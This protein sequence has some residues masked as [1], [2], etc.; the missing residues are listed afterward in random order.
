MTRNLNL[1]PP[2]DGGIVT[3]PGGRAAH[4][5]VPRGNLLRAPAPAGLNAEALAQGNDLA[6]IIGDLTRTLDRL[7]PAGVLGTQTYVLDSSGQATEQYKVPFAALAVDSGSAS[8]LTITN[9]PRSTAPPSGP[10]VAIIKPRAF[11]L[12]NLKGYAWTIY[13]GTPGE[14]VTVQALSRP[15]APV[16]V[17]P[18]QSVTSTLASPYPY[19]NGAVPVSN[20]SGNKANAAAQAVLPAAAGKTTW[21]TGFEL[22][23]GGATAQLL[24][25]ATV[26][27]GAGLSLSYTFQF[28]VGVTTLA[29]PVIVEFP[30]PIPASAPNTAITVSLP[31][32]GAGNTN[33][34][35]SAHGYQL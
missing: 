2:P 21:I 23:G 5:R 32:G 10:G 25:N 28:P 30:L 18:Q 8:T 3:R 35:A 31:A 17:S 24:V 22:T 14:L 4:L 12:A 20:S 15:H 27:D 29:F 9:S 16:S 11:V 13:G 26:S 1:G 7:A 19:P 34:A 33:A 6:A